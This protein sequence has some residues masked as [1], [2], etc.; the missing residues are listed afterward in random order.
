[1]SRLDQYQLAA[2][3]RAFTSSPGQSP[4]SCKSDEGSNGGD[5][6]LGVWGL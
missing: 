6:G 3:T 2:V 5:L 4:A 1:M